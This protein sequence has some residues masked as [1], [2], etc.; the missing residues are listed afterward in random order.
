MSV[1]ASLALAVA[2]PGRP[3]GDA[4]LMALAAQFEAARP[5]ARASPC[6]TRARAARGFEPFSASRRFAEAGPPRSRRSRLV[7]S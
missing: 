7:T 1:P 4:R 6:S 3:G 2:F 5:L